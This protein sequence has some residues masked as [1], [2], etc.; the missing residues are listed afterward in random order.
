MDAADEVKARLSIEDVVAEYVQLKRAGRNFKGLSPFTNERSPSFMVSPEKQIWHDFSSGKGGNVFSFIMEVEGLDF[1]GALELLARKAGVDLGQYSQRPAGESKEKERLQSA[2]TQAS[3]FYQVQLTK[4]Q[5]A[6]QYVREKR[7]LSK[8]TIIAFKLGY[9]PSTGKALLNYLVQ[10]GF[11]HDELKKAGLVTMRRGGLSDMFRDRL[12]I[13]LSDAQGQVVGFT[14]RLL[15]NDPDAP[16]Y[17]NTPATVLY[18]KGRQAYGLHLAKEAIRKQGYVVIVEGNVDVIASWQAGI[19]NI[20]ATAG[21][22]MTVWHL[23]ALKRFTGDIRLC[24]DQDDAGQAAAE[25]AIELADQVDVT[26]RMVVIAGGKDPDELIQHDKAAWEKAVNNPQYVVDWLMDRYQAKADITT[27]VGKRQYSDV[28]LRLIRRLKDQVEQDHYIRLL[29]A[30]IDTT[31]GVLRQKL[32]GTQ[33]QD[34]PRLKK[35]KQAVVAASAIKDKNRIV[36]EQH[37]LSIAC[38]Y[39][40]LRALLRDLPTDI[41]IQPEAL[42]VHD[43]LL[44]YP[45]FDG[46]GNEAKHLQPITDYV[47]ILTLLSEELYQIDDMQV[48]TSQAEQILGRLVAAYTQNKKEQIKQQLD[49]A[50]DEQTTRLLTEVRRLDQLAKVYNSK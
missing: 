31:P 28:V 13:P 22:A 11:T 6:L 32:A 47:K 29:A 21:T 15:Q 12:M 2:L 4:H 33:V 48:V 46:T 50:D 34:S 9:S 36:W 39:P 35:S 17:I 44:A 25:R 7:Q 18:D 1:R 24:F 14:A 10:K 5:S 26:L 23:K 37:L 40:T 45:D 20:V 42:Q 16:K 30:K 49:T 3:H 19:T 41:Y 38:R 8:E 27:A 43:F